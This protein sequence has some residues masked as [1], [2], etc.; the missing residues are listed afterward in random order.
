M[1]G[2][3]FVPEGGEF[4]WSQGAKYQPPSGGG[5]LP[6]GWFR[7]PHEDGTALPESQPPPPRAEPPARE[8]PREE[9]MT[10]R[11]FLASRT[12]EAAKQ[13]ELL[14]QF[15]PPPRVMADRVDLDAGTASF[16][17]YD[18]PLTRDSVESIKM[19][20]AM[21]V[22]R[23]LELERDRIFATVQQQHVQEDSS[24]RG[25]DVP[26]VQGSPSEV[27]P[28]QTGGGGPVQ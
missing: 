4:D 17:G 5:G 1:P 25:T 8:P 10:A 27:E 3:T 22:C 2:T 24:G 14:E 15:V 6:P 20:L 9:R 18:V 21:E 13:Q 19:I 7:A 11:E 26:V 12:A 16:Q 23:I 28:P